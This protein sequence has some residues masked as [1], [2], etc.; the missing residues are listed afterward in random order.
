MADFILKGCGTALVTPFRNGKVD[1][2]TYRKLVER[3]VRSGIDFLVPL[4]TTAETPCLEDDEKIE[5]LKITKEAAHGL[6]IVAGA[7]TN[8]LQHTI[9][10]IKK[11]EPHGADAFLI[12]VPF[13]NKP[14]Q[15]GIYQYFKAVAGSTEKPIVLYNVPGRTGANM[16]AETCLR[17]AKDVKNI[18]AVKEA[19]GNKEQMKS[20]IEGR[21]EGFSILS[22]NDDEVFDILNTGAQGMISVA[23]NIFPKLEMRIFELFNRREK[24]KAHLLANKLQ[25]FYK[26]C[27]VESNP[28]PVKR[29]LKLLGLAEDEMRLPMTSATKTTSDIMQKALDDLLPLE[30]E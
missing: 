28:I 21:P 30:N 10:N 2:D 16:T 27:F 17:L 20:L 12:V 29:G 13:Y 24:E 15:E 4:G 11:L 6:P 19:S 22:G 23:S 7:G 8:S 3:Q 5:L 25:G 18:V 1:Y 26:A 9:R 14:V